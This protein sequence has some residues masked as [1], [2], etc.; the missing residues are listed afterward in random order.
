VSKLF[1]YQFTVEFKSGK[2]NT[3]TDALSRCDEEGPATF[4][5]SLPNFDFFDQFCIEA[6]TLPEVIAKRTEI[7]ARTAG[8]KWAVVDDMVVHDRRLLVPTSATVWVLLLEHAHG[9]GHEG[10]QKALERLRA[11]FFTPDDNK[12]VRDYIRGCVVCQRQKIEHLHPAGLLQPLVVLSLVWSDI[13]MYFVK[14]FP[15]IGGKSVILTVVDRFSKSA[16]FAPLGHPYSA[17]S[18]AKAF[19]DSIV[20]L[21]GLPTSIV[22]DRDPIFTSNMWTNMFRLTET[23]LCTS[24]A[25]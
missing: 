5:L 6:A 7:A 2:Q 22:S 25:F 21:H 1:R 10:V 24:L 16:H 18:V 4:A 19:F 8:P 15:K 11:S 13:A 23:K 12:L 9:M 17:A 20:R 3:T 14:G